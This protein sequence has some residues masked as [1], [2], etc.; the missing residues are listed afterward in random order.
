MS[1]LGGGSGD[2][3]NKITP[4]RITIW[5]V[6]AGVGVYLVVSGLVGILSGGSCHTHGCRTSATGIRRL[7]AWEC[8]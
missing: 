3:K 1:L 5:V 6:V 4:A 8:G 2:D 7:A